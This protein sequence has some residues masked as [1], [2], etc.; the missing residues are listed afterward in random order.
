MY[1]IH[2]FVMNFIVIIV[3]VYL[4]RK[5]FLRSFFCLISYQ[6]DFLKMGKLKIVSGVK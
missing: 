5:S 6:D 2:F 1:I 3:K 4:S